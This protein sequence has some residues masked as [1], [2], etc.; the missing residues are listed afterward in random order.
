E[1]LLDPE[2]LAQ[3]RASLGEDYAIYL[4][5]A[6]ESLRQRATAL[7]PSLTRGDFQEAGRLLHGLKG[8]LAAFGLEADSALCARLRGDLAGGAGLAIRTEAE[9][10][11]GRVLATANEVDRR[12]SHMPESQ[13]T[14]PQA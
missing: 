2:A 11:A 13:T 9:A 7:L 5:A 6:S 8:T 10:L 12:L 1:R 14:G 4:R 3:L